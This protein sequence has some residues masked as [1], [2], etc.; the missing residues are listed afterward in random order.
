[1]FANHPQYQGRP[2][3]SNY[4]YAGANGE[5]IPLP[6]AP[7]MA[8]LADGRIVEAGG[9]WYGRNPST[10]QL[11]VN[12]YSERDYDQRLA[13]LA[14]LRTDRK[15]GALRGRIRK[16]PISG[17]MTKEERD[18]WKRICAEAVSDPTNQ[19]VLRVGEVMSEIVYETMD[20]E[21]LARNLLAIENVNQGDIARVRVR[22]KDIMAFMT[23]GNAAVTE[24]QIEQDWIYPAEG[25]LGCIVTIKEIVLA[26]GSPK[27]LDEKFE[28]M[29]EAIGVREDRLVKFVFDLAASSFNN[30]QTFVTF[31]PAT[32][33][34]LQDAVGGWNLPPATLLIAYDVLQDIRSDPDWH[35]FLGP[36]LRHQLSLEGYL[37]N[38]SGVEIVVDGFRYEN[39]KVLERGEVYMLTTPVALGTWTQR[40]KLQTKGIDKY[41]FGQFKRGWA[42]YEIISATVT[43]GRG[44]AKATRAA[45]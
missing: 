11:E 16:V 12:A 17:K 6:Q 3:P 39:L 2:D 22:K 18:D 10:G 45:A 20:R 14:D 23:L 40:D 13:A 21:G 30:L 7:A 5:L 9:Q 38:I 34:T 8:Q 1:M 29:T 28:D 24:Q 35:D 4:V 15:P 27:L 44:I 41:A 37:P 32:L 42:G 33:T 43:N 31:T 19:S 36:V 26:Q 25:T